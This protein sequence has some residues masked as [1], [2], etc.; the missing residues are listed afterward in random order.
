M[1]TKTARK[2]AEKRHEFMEN[3]LKE[4]YEEW[5]GEC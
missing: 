1:N 5:E 4:F 3:Y 2:M